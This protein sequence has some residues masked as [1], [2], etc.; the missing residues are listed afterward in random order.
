[1]SK[2]SMWRKILKNFRFWGKKKDFH[3]PDSDRFA[4]TIQQA[5][6][7]KPKTQTIYEDITLPCSLPKIL[8]F[9]ALVFL[10]LFD[11]YYLIMC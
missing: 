1:M 11:K 2:D 6:S 9:W 3:V 7:K 10:F 8:G 5:A 4:G